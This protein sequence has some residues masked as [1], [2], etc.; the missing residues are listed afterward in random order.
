MCG[1]YF[2]DDGTDPRQMR[3]IAA[4]L[5]RRAGAEEVK[6]TGEVRPSDQAAVIANSRGMVPS[7]FAMRWGY[8]LPDGRR[9]I[10]ARS[11]SAGEKP[12]FQ[13]GWRHR[14]CAIPASGYFEWFRHGG[15]RLTP[16]A[17]RP[18]GEG[19]VYLAGLYRLE[20]GEAEFTVLTRQSAPEIA[21]IHD[22]M[23][24]LLS[25]E[26]VGEWL[27]PDG[28]P[29]NLLAGAMTEVRYVRA[30]PEAPEQLMMEL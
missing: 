27:N 10:N 4:A 22:R 29:E 9:I 3:A 28:V 19:L 14:R 5:N 18:A 21:F 20:G 25:R 16:Y 30:N 15:K 23:P 24:V 11:E 6:T 7:V 2:I 26:Q 8:R 1:R 12:L 17:I 13:D